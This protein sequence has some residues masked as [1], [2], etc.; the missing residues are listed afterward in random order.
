MLYPLRLSLTG[1]AALAAALVCGFFYAYYCSVMVGFGAAEP[2]VAIAAMQ[3]IN[4]TV[5]N[6]PFAFSFFGTLGFGLMAGLLA[7][8]HLRRPATAALWFGVAVYGLGGFGVT[9]LMN[10][11]L[12]VAL[13]GATVTPDTAAAIWRDYAEPWRF[14]NIVRML[15]S[16]LALASF[17]T[18]LILEA[19]RLRE[20]QTA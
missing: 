10:V 20:R 8:P 16:G 5:R 2:Q 6:L 15:A 17:V 18:A 3:A 11:P 12:N 13:A 9:M 19:M 7:L 1:L 4:A 14:W